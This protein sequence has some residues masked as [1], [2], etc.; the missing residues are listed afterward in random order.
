ML[1]LIER[2]A[3][4]ETI[5]AETTPAPSADKVIDLMAALEASVQAAKGARGRHP[6]ALASV[7]DI[8]GGDA[9]GSDDEVEADE[10][11]AA[12]RS[13]RK[14]PAKKTA[15]KKAPAKKPAAKKAPAKKVTAARKSA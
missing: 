15:A 8:D 3:G 1:E 14:A 4:G 7:S 11:P 6:T 13:A 9:A 5:V 2:K 12:K 10:A